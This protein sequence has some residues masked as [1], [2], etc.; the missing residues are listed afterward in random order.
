MSRELEML[1][2]GMTSG[3]WLS[4][5]LLLGLLTA[6][7]FRPERIS[8]WPL[9][10]LA[11][12][13]FAFSLIIGPLL[14]AAIYLLSGLS[15]GPVYPIGS[16]GSEGPLLRLFGVLLNLAPAVLQG[17]SI[18]FALMALDG[19]RQASLPHNPPRH[20]LDK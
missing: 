20:P 5:A 10:R 4:V 9:F 19:Q 16:A 1:L 13:L 14:Q 18:L 6:L 2:S 12:M 17:F 11:G 3:G 8:N 15:T 7:L